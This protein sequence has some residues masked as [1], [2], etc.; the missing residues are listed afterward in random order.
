MRR[1]PLKLEDNPTK[2]FS[3]KYSQ[4]H[5]WFNFSLRRRHENWEGKIS[6]LEKGRPKNSLENIWAISKPVLCSSL[7]PPLIPPLIPPYSSAERSKKTR[8]SARTAFC[9]ARLLFCLIERT[10]GG[11]CMEFTGSPIAVSL[12]CTGRPAVWNSDILRNQGGGGQDL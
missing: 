4:F 3:I 9:L 8:V 2:L 11:C 10:V 7:C 5:N 6:A 1:Y 12:G